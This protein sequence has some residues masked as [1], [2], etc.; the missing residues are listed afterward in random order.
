MEERPSLE[1]RELTYIGAENII[2]PLGT[3]AQAT[4]EN[5]LNGKTSIRPVDG[6]DTVDG[7]A[8]V[9][10]FP[11]GMRPSME[12]L[13]SNCFEASLRRVNLDLLAQEKVLFILSTT[14]G[15][16]NRLF[17]SIDEARLPN[18]LDK[19][20]EKL[21]FKGDSYI[22]S[23]ACISGLLAVINA[24]D[25]IEQGVYD[26][27]IVC[28]ADLVSQFTLSGFASLYA[29]DGKPCAPFDADRA[30][31]NL[32]EGAAS[33][34]LSGDPAIFKEKPFQILGGACANDANHISGPSRTGE[35]LYRSIQRSL[36]A[37]HKVAEEIDQISAHGTATRY[38]DDM[39][40]IA[41][42]RCGLSNVPL[43][44]YKGYFG[45]TLGAAGVMELSL[46]FTSTRNGS[47]LPCA[48]HQTAGTTEAINVITQ[49]LKAKSQTLLKT[50]SGFGGCNAAA[51]FSYEG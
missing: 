34:I 43:Q 29:M 5:A 19:V 42:N 48:G 10:K 3:S 18:L 45:H 39:E 46:L 26:H 47:M 1:R 28:G 44:S 11:E 23:N 38:N 21:N 36:K 13:A 24:S 32:G 12:D 17:N 50:S 41:F 51:I 2:C 22:V 9:S 31:I 27:A 25:L 4:F 37:A 14:K 16:V 40:S 30:G 33:L 35:G 8:H 15:E 20:A 6:Y 49:T 7:K